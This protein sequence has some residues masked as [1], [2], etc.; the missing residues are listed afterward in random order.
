[1]D[2]KQILEN[3]IKIKINAEKSSQIAALS[4]SN[5]LLYDG[6]NFESESS[7]HCPRVALMRRV[8]NIQEE[9]DIKSFISNNHGR[10]FEDFLRNVLS[11]ESD[12]NLQIMEEEEVE[13]KLED[14]YGNLL[15]TARPDKFI[16][17]NDNIYPVEVK[18]IQ[19][20]STAYYVFI[21]NKPKL[22]ALI[23]IAI[24][25]IGHNKKE[26]F[27]LY[28]ASNWFSGFAGKTRWKVD[29]QIKTFKIELINGDIYCDGIVTIVSYEKIIHGS[30]KF[31]DLQTTNT[32]P[33][34]PV[35]LDSIGEPASYSGCAYCFA[36]DTCDVA[37]S[38]GLNL[39]EFFSKFKE[40]SN[41]ND[42]E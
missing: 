4:G 21:K 22:G 33:N 11:I 40:L 23:Q 34:R 2:L 19:S 14:D 28:C 12:D 29:P 7:D 37:D 13:V 6:F 1:M 41:G 38:E 3:K 9:K 30:Y 18:T 39:K 27:I 20:N 32:L 25:L 35:F 10:T 17:Y 31:L 24:Y 15:L 26:G 8:A 42:K 36:S 5:A 16:K